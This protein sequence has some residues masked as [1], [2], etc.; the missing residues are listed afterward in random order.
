MQRMKWHFL[1][2]IVGFSLFGN[3]Q[4]RA[5][6]WDE[7]TDQFVDSFKSG[8][9]RDAEKLGQQALSAA[10]KLYGQ[11]HLNYATS[12]YYLARA[13]QQLGNTRLVEPLLLKSIRCYIPDFY[14][15]E[16]VLPSTKRHH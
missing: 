16:R 7:L 4:V 12:A 14:S 9:Y 5:Q 6:S 1:S 2:I 10:G 15:P 8:H 11:D 3:T 13:E